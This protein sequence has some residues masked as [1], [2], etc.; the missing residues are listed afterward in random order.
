MMKKNVK[1]SKPSR[2][3]TKDARRLVKKNKNKSTPRKKISSW[4][5]ARYRRKM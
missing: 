3:T 4:S 5:R 2:K 1:K